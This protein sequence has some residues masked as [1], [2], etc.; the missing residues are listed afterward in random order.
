MIVGNSATN[1]GQIKFNEGT[2]NGS[3]FI[4][5]KSPNKCWYNNI[6]TT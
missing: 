4:G 1:G 2:N 5:L 6:Y 3:N